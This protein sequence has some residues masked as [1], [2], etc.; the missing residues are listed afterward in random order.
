M[1]SSFALVPRLDWAVFIERPAEE[2]HEALYSSLLRTSGLLL[3]GLAL[4]LFASFFVARRVIRPLTS[5]GRR[6]R[7]H[8]EW[9]LELS[10]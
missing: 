5:A 8:R 2:V 3:T 10:G 9:R 4:A 7:P 6:S 1:I